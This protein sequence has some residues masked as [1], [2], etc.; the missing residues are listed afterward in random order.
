MEFAVPGGLIGVGTEIDPSRCRANHLVG[1]VLGLP[2]FLPPTYSRIVVK[3]DLML[4]II[5]S[6]GGRVTQVPVCTP[7]PP[8]ASVA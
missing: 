4:Y 6:A 1:Q 2:G 8:P 3:Y 5:Q 7:N